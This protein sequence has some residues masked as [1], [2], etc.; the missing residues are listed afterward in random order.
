MKK[1]SADVRKFVEMVTK[2]VE[3]NTIDDQIDQFKALESPKRRIMLEALEKRSEYAKKEEPLMFRLL[4]MK[5]TPDTMAMVMARYNALN[6]MDGS[7]GEYYKLRA[8][9]EKLVSMPLGIYKDMPV[10]LEDGQ[11]FR[12]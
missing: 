12:Y 6:T 2:P 8:W 10:R 5:L 11:V 3:E 1:E 4:Q 9:M 7:T